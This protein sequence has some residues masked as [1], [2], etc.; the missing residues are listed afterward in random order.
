MKNKKH[1]ICIISA[2]YNEE[3]NLRKLINNFDMLRLK[4][5]K[6]GYIPKLLLVNDGSHDNSKTI[7]KEIIKS[8]Q[9]IK[10]INL[11][12]NYGQQIAIHT[13][14]KKEKMDFYG[15]LDSDCQ[16]NPN[17]FIQMISYLKSKEVDLVQM[18]KKYGNYEGDIKK[19]FSKY[20][21][22]VFSIITKIDIKQGSSDFYL[23]TLKVRNKI[24]KSNFSKLFLR[25]FIHFLGYKKYY[26]DYTP[27]KRKKGKSKYT[28]FKQIDFALTAIYLYAKKYFFGMFV[29][30][31]FINYKF[32]T[33]LIDKNLFQ[34]LNNI[35]ISQLEYL[36]LLFGIISL[37]VSSGLIY[38]FIQIHKKIIITTKME[39][40]KRLDQSKK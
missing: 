10:L 4:L 11:K 16:Q 33:L 22:Y 37:F 38:F 26:I 6:I 20:F 1:S 15:V 35:E 2:F 24:I 14:L 3:H 17:Y 8:K 19:Y 12:K 27:L 30:L 39:Y 28:F 13:A 36:Y 25:G 18:K 5:I 32:I 7:V 21:Y 9:Y 23:F 40:E 34:N 29:F 31:L